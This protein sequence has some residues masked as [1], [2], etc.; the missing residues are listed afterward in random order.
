MYHDGNLFSN[1]NNWWEKHKEKYETFDITQEEFKKFPFTKGLNK[2]DVLF[3]MG[4]NPKKLKIGDVI[5]FEAGVQNPLIHRI[6]GITEDSTG[7]RLFETIG[8]NNNGQLR[9]EQ[10]IQENQIIGKATLKPAP[11][12]GWGKLIFFEPMR[13]PESRGFCNEN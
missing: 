7:K 11:Y 5:I 13:N 8:D 2:G 4:A 9:I 1:S 6:V 3:V 12:L 10:R